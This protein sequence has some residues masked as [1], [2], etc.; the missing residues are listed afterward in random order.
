MLPLLLG[1][2][3]CLDGCLFLKVRSILRSRLQ[4]V[5]W[6][7]GVCIRRL[8]LGGLCRVVFGFFL[9]FC[10]WLLCRLGVFVGCFGVRVG[11]GL[12]FCIFYRCVLLFVC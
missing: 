2:F 4:R 3:V 5:D 12:V 11:S 6:L 10:S 8:V 9:L 1:W 7:M